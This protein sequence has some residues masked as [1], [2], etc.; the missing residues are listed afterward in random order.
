ATSSAAGT[1]FQTVTSIG[2]RPVAT[3]M[4]LSSA[5]PLGRPETISSAYWGGADSRI[6][7][8]ADS[9]GASTSVRS[10]ASDGGGGSAGAVHAESSG[11]E[12]ERIETVEMLRMRVMMRIA[13]RAGKAPRR[14]R[15]DAA[16]DGA[17]TGRR[18]EVPDET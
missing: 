6:W 8:S 9:I 17:K 5:Q 14:G 16:C 3:S 10:R 1:L 2:S 18:R 12:D 7:I 4:R 13:P 11:S 15:A